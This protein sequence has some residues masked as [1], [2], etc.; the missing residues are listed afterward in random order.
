MRVARV[1]RVPIFVLALLA[2]VSAAA[3]A[4]GSRT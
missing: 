4:V 2:T 1:S 3:S